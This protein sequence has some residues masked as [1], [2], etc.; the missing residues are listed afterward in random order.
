MLKSERSAP[1]K[2]WLQAAHHADQVLPC[3]LF[4]RLRVSLSPGTG[5]RSAQWTRFYSL[6]LGYHRVPLLLNE[7]R[8][9]TV[10]VI[11]VAE[12]TRRHLLRPAP[13]RVTHVLSSHQTPAPRQLSDPILAAG[14][15]E[16]NVCVCELTKLGLTPG[17]LLLSPGPPA[18]AL[19]QN[20]F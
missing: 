1:G 3:P 11:T 2:A 17:P 10:K 7:H 16:A 19:T 14:D 6:T 15:T 4:P 8:G 18:S 9:L 5:N 20:R 13:L 12:A